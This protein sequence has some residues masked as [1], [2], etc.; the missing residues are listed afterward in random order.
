MIAFLASVFVCQVIAF[1][2]NRKKTFNS[3]NNLA[4]SITAYVLMSLFILIGLQVYTAPYLIQMF[5]EGTTSY[6]T[7]S[8]VTK[9]FWMTL[10]FI[11]KYISTKF[12]IMRDRKP[13]GNA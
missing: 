8:M 12:F 10:S 7:A 6:E 11:I 1:T 4:F 9:G 2:Q 13:K 5:E 3:T